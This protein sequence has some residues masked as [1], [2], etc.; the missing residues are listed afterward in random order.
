VTAVERRP[1]RGSYDLVAVGASLGGVTALRVLLGGLPAGFATPLAIVQHRS[2][3]GGGVDGDSTLPA[4]LAEGARIPVR[5]PTDREPLRPGVA[6]LA[7][8]GYHMLV[9]RGFLTLSLDAPVS[10]ARPSIDVLFETAAEAYGRRLV[11]VL[12]TCSS[13]DGAAG[14]LAVARRGGLTMVEDPVSAHSPVAGRSAL[15]LTSVHHVLPL[16]RIA[17]VLATMVSPL[18]EGRS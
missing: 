14:M 18:A 7:P 9:E 5:E 8:P 15:A 10:Y 12:L 2:P 6:Y 3:E 4:L 11:A 13:D 1:L 16:D 17:G